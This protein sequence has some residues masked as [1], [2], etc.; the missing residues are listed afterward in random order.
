[1][2]YWNFS[3]I[4]EWCELKFNIS[5]SRGGLPIGDIKIKCLQ[6]LDWWETDL[7]I[8]VKDIDLDNLNGDILSEK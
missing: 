6:V 2:M 5:I 4:R 3:D 1:M 8:R 7:N